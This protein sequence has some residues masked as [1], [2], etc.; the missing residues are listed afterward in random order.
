MKGPRNTKM[1]LDDLPV[2]QEENSLDVA[3]KNTYTHKM[4]P[5][6]TTE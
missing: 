2:L 4:A 1:L 5:M 6:P 3:S